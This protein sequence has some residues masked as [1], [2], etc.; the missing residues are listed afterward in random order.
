[1]RSCACGCGEIPPLATRTRPYLGLVKGEPVR[2]VP[3]HQALVPPLVKFRRDTVPQVGGCWVWNGTRTRAGYA[4][5]SVECKTVYVHRWAY[6]HFVGPIPKGLELDHLCRNTRCVNP[7]HLEPVTHA[8]NNRRAV[9]HR[10]LKITEADKAAIVAAEPYRGYK[11][12]LAE[13]YGI[14][15]SYVKLIRREARQGAA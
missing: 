3:G 15:P 14:S 5:M 10:K 12:D 1:M 2:Y 7:D 11:R 4:T 6:E 13:K 8:E 9:P